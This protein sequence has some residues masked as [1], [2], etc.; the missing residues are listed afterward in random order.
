MKYSLRNRL[1]IVFSFSL[2]V[3]VSGVAFFLEKAFDKSLTGQ[4]Q[5]RMKTQ[6][7]MLL[8]AAEEEE[9]GSL[10]IPEVVREDAF[11]QID[12]GSYAFVYS[13]DQE[14]V[15]RSFSAVDLELELAEKLTTGEFFFDLAV[16]ENIRF[17]RLRYAVI[18]ESY[19][20]TE[21]YYQF[22]VLHEAHLLK[23]V[24]NDFRYA[25]WY[26]LIFVLVAMLIVQFIALRW[27]LAPLGLVAKDLK[28]IE[29]G[30]QQALSKDYPT[31][32]IPLTKNLNLLIESE[33]TQR[34]KYR[35]TFSNLAHSL[36]TP[37]A[38][39]KGA[40]NSDATEDQSDTIHSQVTR[41]DEIIQYQLSRAVAGSQGHMLASVNVKI[42]IEKILSA[43]SKVYQDKQ[44]ELT[45][46]CDDSVRFYGDEGDFMEMMGNLLD[47]ACKWTSQRVLV[48]VSQS[49]KK[50]SYVLDIRIADDG[51]GIPEDMREKVI[52]RG[53]RLD[54]QTE[55]QGIGLSVVAELVHQ[56]GGK[57]SIKESN[58]QGAEFQLLFDFRRV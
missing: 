28:N 15:W 19:D 46:N 17:Y 44:L 55:G 22:T 13:D 4:L 35:N 29:S 6:L 30:K 26:G 1:I 37:L 23:D 8:T 56:Y 14:E 2:I 25:L 3:L 10:Y 5:Q 54:E 21:S 20:G 57:I 24:I 31:E 50:N 33:R 45:L 48:D 16:I 9:P 7:F 51:P 42:G 47:N 34:E 43:L 49:S 40:V 11:N 27:G 53:G 39:I 52:T 41:M 36:K 12:S 38:V 58:I 32:L 18:W